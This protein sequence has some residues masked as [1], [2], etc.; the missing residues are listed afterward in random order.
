MKRAVPFFGWVLFFISLGSPHVR[1]MG[2]ACGEPTGIELTPIGVDLNGSYQVF[3]RQWSNADVSL[4]CASWTGTIAMT[5]GPLK[6]KV[7][8]SKG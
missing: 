1:L 5:A 2:R 7:F 6:G 3:S 4:D 8:S